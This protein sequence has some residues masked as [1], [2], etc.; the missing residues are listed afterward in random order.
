MGREPTKTD[1]Y[2]LLLR[3]EFPQKRIFTEIDITQG[4]NCPR[5]LHNNDVKTQEIRLSTS[6]QK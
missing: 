6:K 2:E 4:S 5:K 1:F 3:V